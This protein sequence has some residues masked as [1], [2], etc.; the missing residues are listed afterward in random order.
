VIDSSQ[1][2]RSTEILRTLVG[3]PTVNPMERSYSSTTPVERPVIEY[4]ESLFEP[5][6][7]SLSRQPCSPI[8]ESLLIAVDGQSTGPATLLESH[9]DTVPADDWLDRAF[10]PRIKNGRLYGRGACDDKGSLAAMVDAVLQVL[11]SGE[12]PPQPILLLAAGDE[13][14]GQTGIKHFIQNHTTLKIGRGVFGE[15]TSCQPIIQHKGTIRWDLTVRGR[16]SHSSEPEK[17]QNAI[18]DMLQVIE[19]LRQLQVEL[20]AQHKNP[21]LTPPTITVTMIRGGTTRNALPQ[22]CTA[23]VDFRIVPGMNCEDAS[24]H[25]V[26]AVDTMELATSHGPFQCFAPP[27]DTAPDDPFAL[28]VVQICS[29]ALGNRAKLLGVPYGSDASYSPAG[30]RS[31]VLGPGEIGNAH[32]I[33][34][35]VELSQVQRCAEIYHS[36]VMQDWASK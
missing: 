33:D 2:L 18:L 14:C 27:L 34:E 31:V 10:Q 36:I 4:L 30:A 26:E 16:S 17:G 32:T 20:A 24:R 23:A 6:G 19:R 3:L 25:V 21:L 35:S 29:R 5:Y 8:H 9:I 7:V 15:P 1:T 22:E 11:D 13:E 12:R 28:A